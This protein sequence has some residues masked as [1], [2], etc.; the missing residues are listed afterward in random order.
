MNI[1]VIGS[2][3]KTGQK[4]LE[5]LEKT[6]HITSGMIR[7]SE[8][9]K[10]VTQFKAKVL[11]GD[12]KQGIDTLLDGIDAIMFVAGSR[13]KDINGV[14]YQG[15]LNAVNAAKKAN[16]ER[17]IYLGS[18][19]AEKKPDQYVQELKD[20]HEKEGLTVP[21]GLLTNTEKEGYYEY[22]KVK[23][24]A[25]SFLIG[26]GLNYTILRAGLLT[27]D[28]GTGS[29]SMTEGSLDAFGKVSRENV[30][31][32]FIEALTNKHTQK[33]TYTVLDGATPISEAFG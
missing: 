14:D 19:N 15:L 27:Q 32:T 3:G 29:V 16:L 2:T 17:F 31:D 21:K 25:E 6:A 22:V 13:G 8:Q 20:F 26:S 30:A 1:L 33:K 11:V 9:E 4:L 10:M 23:G 5:K 12:L 7:L 18:I 24:K 28:V